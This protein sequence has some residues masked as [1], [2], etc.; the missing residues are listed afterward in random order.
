MNRDG[1]QPRRRRGTLQQQQGGLKAKRQGDMV[2]D[3]F[4]RASDLYQAEGLIDWTPT[5][6]PFSPKGTLKNGLLFGHYE[7]HGQA[8]RIVTLA[9]FGGKTC[10]IEIKKVTAKEQESLGE[11]RGIHQLPQM[12]KATKAGAAAYYVLYWETHDQWQ[13]HPL[14]SIEKIH[15][16]SITFMRQTGLEIPSPNGYPEWYPVVKKHIEFLLNSTGIQLGFDLEQLEA[17]IAFRG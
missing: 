1:F 11:R 10:W 12:V 2:E 9:E 17:E 4:D 16:K 13:L 6:P 5:Y 3:L 15:E 14:D 8:D 7:R